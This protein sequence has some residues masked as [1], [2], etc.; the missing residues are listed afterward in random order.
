[1]ALNLDKDNNIECNDSNILKILK[2]IDII[3][4]TDNSLS[5]R[6][7]LKDLFKKYFE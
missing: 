6:L 1:M 2:Q 5:A 7:N 3:P 4:E